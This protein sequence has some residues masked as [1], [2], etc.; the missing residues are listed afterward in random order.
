MYKVNDII[1][2]LE[3]L[4]FTTKSQKG[5]HIIMTNVGMSRPIIL[6]KYNQS[7]VVSINILKKICKQANI[8]MEDII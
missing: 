3:K 7:T 2:R 8:S 4:G 1:K 5:S 6:V